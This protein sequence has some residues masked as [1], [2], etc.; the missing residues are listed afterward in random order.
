M[1]RNIFIPSL[2]MLLS[3]GNISENKTTTTENGTHASS[4]NSKI[5]NGIQIN[6]NGLSVSQA[7][8]L[9]EDGTR[10]PED[11]TVQ[12]NQQI[13]LRLIMEGWKDKDGKVFPGASETILT[14]EGDTV[15]AEP[16][17]FESYAQTGVD[18]KDAE[19]ITLFATITKL[20]KLYDYFTVQFRLWDK[21]SNAE[22]TGSYKLYIK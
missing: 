12:I 2:F 10:V 18:K 9:F 3:C 16:D 17:L 15:L 21:Q 22:T 11:N 8:L 20:D 1:K 14:N 4:V 5:K 7:F 13:S 19:Y 6:Q